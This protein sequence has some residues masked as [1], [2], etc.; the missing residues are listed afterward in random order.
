MMPDGKKGMESLVLSYSQPEHPLQEGQKGEF[1]VC[2]IKS[3]VLS[4]SR[5]KDPLQEGQEGE[6]EVSG[7]K[8]PLL[9][10]LKK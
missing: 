10:H 9:S 8:P 4:L 3:L 2:G 7:I 5:P 6:F 1:V